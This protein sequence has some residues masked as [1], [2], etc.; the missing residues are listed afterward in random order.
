MNVQKHPGSL[1]RRMKFKATGSE[2][3]SLRAV[4]FDEAAAGERYTAAVMATAPRVPQR[5]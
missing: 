5:F 4:E 1:R 3:I 2:S